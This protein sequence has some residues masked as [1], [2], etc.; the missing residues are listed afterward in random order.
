MAK[1]ARNRNKPNATGRNPTSRF[2]RLDYRILNSNA[3]R[4][5]TP[6]ARSLLIEITMLYNGENN[7]SL[8]LS[9]RDAAD[10]M[11]VVDTHAA[12]RAL[13]ELQSLGFVEMTQEAHFAV[14]ASEASR[15]R[16]W[17]L[18]WLIGPGRK[19]PSWEFYDREPDPQTPARKRM[20]RGQRALKTYRKLRDQN[21]LPVVDSTTTP[22]FEV[23]A[24]LEP[25]VDSTTL[26]KGNGGNEPSPVV[27]ESTTHIATLMGVGTAKAPVDVSDTARDVQTVILPDP[28][29]AF[30]DGLRTHLIDHLK[31]SAVG[32]QSQIAV[33]VGCP[34]GT[35]S[36]F[37]GGRSL[38]Q[39]HSA[40]LAQELTRRAAIRPRKAGA[41]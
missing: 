17:R 11:G 32:E 21:K 30:L 28:R 29:T 40:R 8:Y 34:G 1:K 25:V 27:V 10:R 36:K 7:G 2:V 19:L 35:L 5:L 14:K 31:K 26:A 23:E 33:A 37:V 24:P 13:D 39:N 9:V 6:N 3:Y 4:S 20:E 22:P 18:A 12:K 15:A 38:P 41:A 16:C